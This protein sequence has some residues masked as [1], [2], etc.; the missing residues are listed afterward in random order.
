MDDRTLVLKA[1]VQFMK[2]QFTVIT[3]PCFYLKFYQVGPLPNSNILNFKCI[4]K[5]TWSKLLRLFKRNKKKSKS[6]PSFLNA[7]MLLQSLWVYI[8]RIILH[9]IFST[10]A[11]AT[12]RRRLIEY[13]FLRNNLAC[14]SISN[15]Q[16]LNGQ[17]Q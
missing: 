10:R 14:T 7:W 3:K 17:I 12:D 15:R 4:N 2:I 13:C 5:I 6:V 11:S 16:L 9:A 1:S 8:L